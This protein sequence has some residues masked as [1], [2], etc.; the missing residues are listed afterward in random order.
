MS[1]GHGAWGME[2]GAEGM[3]RDCFPF[4]PLRVAMTAPLSVIARN[5][6]IPIKAWGMGQRAWGKVFLSFRA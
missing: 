2:H 3:G 6:A 4:A 1:M 5:E